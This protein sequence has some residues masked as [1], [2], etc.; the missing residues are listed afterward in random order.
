MW[1][2]MC[3][4]GC[5][6]SGKRSD[7]ITHSLVALSGTGDGLNAR[8]LHRFAVEHFR[9]NILVTLYLQTRGEVAERLKAAV[10]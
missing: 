1:R 6:Q 5:A 8:R 4:I 3:P 2:E 9:I 10:C 7:D